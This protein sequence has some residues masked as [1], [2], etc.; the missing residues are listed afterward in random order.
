MGCDKTSKTQRSWFIKYSPQTTQTALLP[1][2]QALIRLSQHLVLSRPSSSI[3]FPGSPT[4][5]D[6]DILT[7][8]EDS[9]FLSS[10]DRMGLRNLQADLSR[11][12]QRA[13]ERQVKIVIDAEYR[14]VD[15]HMTYGSS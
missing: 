15:I 5:R 14:F 3:P 11:I 2:P 12:C 4:H 7:V 9:P 8:P 10:A 1:D 13:K 6:L